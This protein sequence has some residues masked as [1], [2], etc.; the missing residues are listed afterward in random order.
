MSKTILLIDDDDV[1]RRILAHHL[2]EAGYRVAS[3][4]RGGPALEVL[5]TTDIDLVVT[6]IQMPEMN[7]YE[8]LKRVQ[9]IS[10]ETP[11][12]VMTAFGS[13]DSAVQAMKLG[14]EDYLTKPFNKEELLL[15][16]SKALEHHQ[17]VLENRHLRR[18]IDEH[19]VLENIVGSSIFEIELPT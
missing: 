13:I 7:G 11:V 12:I 8:L 9:V 1:L 4:S 6:D 17:L 19:F 18:F 2:E 16:V 10:P 5:T 14:A 15:N 3:Q